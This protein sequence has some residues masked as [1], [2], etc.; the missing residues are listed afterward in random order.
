MP[1]AM[2]SKLSSVLR[3]DRV[4]T[5]LLAATAAY[6]VVYLLSDPNL[7]G[8]AASPLSG[9]FSPPPSAYPGWFGG[10][11]QGQYLI[12]AHTLAGLHFGQLAT[13]QVYTYGIG[14]PIVGVPGIW[15][16]FLKDPFV[17]FDLFAFV[18]VTYAV[19]RAGSKLISPVAGFLAAFGLVFA[20]PLIVYV[21][22]P[23]NSTVSMVVMAFV[24]LTLV[25]DEVTRS[26]AFALGMMLGWSYTA[27]FIDVVWLG[28]IAVAC[29]YRGSWRD[30]AR[31]LFT[32]GLVGLLLV[33]VPVLYL[34]YKAFGSP[35]STP[36][37]NHLRT[38]GGS[39]QGLG[40]YHLR[41]VPNSFLGIFVS[42][43]WAGS[44][45][46]YRGLLINFFW[47]LGAI[48]G[49]VILWRR[50]RRR[51]F[52][53]AAGVILIVDYVFY[54]SFRADGNYSLA[55]GV[56]HYFKDFFPVIALFAAGL[57]DAGLRRLAV[58]RWMPPRDDTAGAPM[59]QEE[60]A[61]G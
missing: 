2:F 44:N 26:R 22:Q 32:P 4:L 31:R 28:V 39:D 27:R 21:D 24:L 20:T 14:Y 8:G 41:Q 3:R 46:P 37:V 7:P 40:S 60:V 57:I 54:L 15:L 55:Y 6:F 34:N 47:A 12:I 5:V 13:R 23:L 45:I 51:A 29:V 1:V 30:V 58:D 50:G 33:V 19:Y 10:Y 11:D 25:R 35:F 49:F 61:D 36:Y 53:A 52:L 56:L 9:W 17:F 43:L 16:G 48:P 38:G 59:G 42:P 18:F